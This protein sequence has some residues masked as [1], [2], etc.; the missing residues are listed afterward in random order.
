MT[1]DGQP[2]LSGSTGPGS[3][4]NADLLDGLDSTA[5]ATSTHNHY[6]QTWLGSAAIGL[7][8]R[9]TNP[10]P[11]PGGVA[12]IRGRQGANAGVY[13]DTPAGVWGEAESGIG[14]LGTTSADFPA[15]WGLNIASNGFASAVLGS[16]SSASARAIWGTASATNGVTYGI[17]GDSASSGGVGVYGIHTANTGTAPGVQGSTSSTS[18]NAV[19]V[20]GQVT[21]TS[22]DSSSAAVRGI[23]NGTGG[24]GIGVWGSQAGSGYGVY[25]TAPSGLG[26]YGSTTSGTGV[27]GSTTSGTGV[28]GSASTGAG[29][30]G[31][32]TSGIGVRA[33]SSSANIIEG[34]STGG[35]RRFIVDN[36]GAVHADG[37]YS[38]PAADFA[39]MLPAQDTLEPGDVLVVGEDGKLT[40]CTQAA[41]ENVVGVYST[42]PAFLGGAPD[43]AN[44]DGK[45]PLAVVGIVPVKVTNENGAIKPGNLLVASSTAGRAMKA[46]ADPKIGTVIGKAL[47]SFD[48]KDGIVQMLVLQH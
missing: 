29:V 11:V 1:I 4:L 23:N 21:S 16:S 17:Y 27:F 32:S 19:G 41:Q 9:T 10:G 18:A 48:A 15:V 2:V 44:L 42:K 34:W 20:L 13:F 46:G 24:L 7:D 3:G 26:V 35:G 40:R 47:A 36:A 28:S 45:V 14:V 37:A 33:E 30:N 25:G 12:A 8:V 5:F 22:P 43:T 31:I 6:G 39:E 38:S